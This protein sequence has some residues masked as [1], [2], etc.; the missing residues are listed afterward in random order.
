MYDQPSEAGAET[1]RVWPEVE[2]LSD[3]FKRAPQRGSRQQLRDMHAHL[4]RAHVEM[5]HQIMHT[6][7]VQ[8]KA[9]ARSEAASETVAASL[10]GEHQGWA[11]GAERLRQLEEVQTDMAEQLDAAV[12]MLR[13]AAGQLRVASA[14]AAAFGGGGLTIQQDENEGQAD[15]KRLSGCAM[16]KQLVLCTV[17]VA[18]MAL[19]CALVCVLPA[20]TLSFRN[21]PG[22]GVCFALLPAEVKKW[23]CGAGVEREESSA[24][25]QS[26]YIHVVLADLWRGCITWAWSQ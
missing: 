10:E 19:G 26:A 11:R 1:P 21:F 22:G 15:L 12:Q 13:M 24:T 7:L 16:F 5:A 14:S 4:V 18:L 25:W 20:S 2:N 23:H 9:C 17:C 3:C 6:A 8:L